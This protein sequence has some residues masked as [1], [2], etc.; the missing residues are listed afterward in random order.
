MQKGPYSFTE[1]SWCLASGLLHRK[2]SKNNGKKKGRE[3]EIEGRRKKGRRERGRE[4]E[5]GS[6]KENT[7]VFPRNAV[8]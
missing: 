2:D 6:L 7:F 1:P 5:G 4:R 3:G 8:H